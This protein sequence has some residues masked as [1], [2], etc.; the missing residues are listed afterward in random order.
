[1]MCPHEKMAVFGLTDEEFDQ[2]SE[3][4]QLHEEETEEDPRDSEEFEMSVHRQGQPST[5]V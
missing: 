3:E 1:M 2:Y 4:Y 5:G